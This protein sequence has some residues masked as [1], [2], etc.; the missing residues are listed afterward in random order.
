[1]FPRNLMAM[2]FASALVFG[3]GCKERG[4]P[5]PAAAPQA[6]PEKTAV[7]PAEAPAGAFQAVMLHVPEMTERLKLV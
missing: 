7:A 5:A 3:A 1:M 2:T 6:E 4:A